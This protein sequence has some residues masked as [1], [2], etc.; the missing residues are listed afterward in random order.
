ML[1]GVAP[2]DPWTFAIATSVVALVA[3]AA[4]LQPALRASRIDP[5]TALRHE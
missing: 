1:Y 5:M 4:A 3:F 2:D